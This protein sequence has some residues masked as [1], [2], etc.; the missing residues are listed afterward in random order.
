MRENKLDRRSFVKAAGCFIAAGTNGFPDDAPDRYLD[1]GNEL[2]GGMIIP[3]YFY[4]TNGGLSDRFAQV[5]WASRWLA[6]NGTGGFDKLVAIVNVDSGPGLATDPKYTSAIDVVKSAGGTV[7][8]YVATGYGNKSYLSITTEIDSWIS[9]YP[10]LDGIFLDEWNGQNPG[11]AGMYQDLFWHVTVNR[12]LSSCVCNPGVPFSPGNT[13]PDPAWWGT[14]FVVHENRGNLATEISLPVWL[15][16]NSHADK[17]AVLIHGLS[18][19][20]RTT[21]TIVDAKSKGARWFYVTDDLLPNPW[22]KIPGEIAGATAD[23]SNTYWWNLIWS[24][25]KVHT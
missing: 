23:G 17:G 8:G 2:A 21:R 3:A 4:P 5:A 7:L 20:A 6:Q 24:I 11:F 15:Q 9:Y 18:S 22:D 25:G 10:N 16:T 12:Q 13:N 1:R 14:A 19:Q